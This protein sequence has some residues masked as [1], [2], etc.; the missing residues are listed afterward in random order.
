MDAERRAGDLGQAKREATYAI[1]NFDEFGAGGAYDETLEMKQSMQGVRHSIAELR[2]ASQATNEAAA[3]LLGAV[4]KHQ[5]VVESHE[6]RLDR[7]KITVEAI[8][9]DVCRPRERRPSH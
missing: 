7:T 9:E 1:A 3:H 4:E 2:D 6:G 8:L 5:Q